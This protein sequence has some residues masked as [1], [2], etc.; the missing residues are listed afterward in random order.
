MVYCIQLLGIKSLALA[1]TTDC[2]SVHFLSALSY[3]SALYIIDKTRF[4]TAA[5]AEDHCQS[6][7]GARL[8]RA[9]SWQV[10]HR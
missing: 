2:N 4:P 9:G 5:A 3:Q 8:A 6:Q 1:D 10:I 7:Y